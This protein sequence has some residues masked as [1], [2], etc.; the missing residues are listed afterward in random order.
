M[1][2]G[3]E[4]ETVFVKMTRAFVAAVMVVL[5][6]ILLMG[7]QLASC[8]LSVLIIGVA[9]VTILFMIGSSI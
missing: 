1:L 5:G 8:N 6:I 2:K 7:I 4:Y 3:L 9:A